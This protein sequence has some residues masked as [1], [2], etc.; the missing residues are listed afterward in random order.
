MLSTHAVHPMLS[1]SMAEWLIRCSDRRGSVPRMASRRA[2][3]G[4]ISS[5]TLC[6]KSSAA[7]ARQLGAAESLEDFCASDR[8]AAAVEGML[9]EHAAAMAAGATSKPG[10]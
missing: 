2:R 5:A 10:A 6:T 9:A 3:R 1:T 4:E 7:L 8:G